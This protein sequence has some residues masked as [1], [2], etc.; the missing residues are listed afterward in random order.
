MRSSK[1]ELVFATLP[2]AEVGATSSDS[3]P[4]ALAMR[5]RASGS[6]VRNN[7]KK[8]KAEDRAHIL[9]WTGTNPP[10]PVWVAGPGKDAPRPPPLSKQEI[11]R[12]HNERQRARRKEER[13]EPIAGLAR[14]L[15]YDCI[16]RA[17]RA[18]QSWYSALEA[19]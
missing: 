2:T 14:Q 3:T 9:R 6:N 16:E 12:R 5:T 4:D 17:R 8:L 10:A 7:L 15:T 19:A 11:Q 13:V 1:I 18:P